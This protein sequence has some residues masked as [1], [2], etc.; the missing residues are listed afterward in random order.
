MRKQEHVERV[1]IAPLKPRY[2]EDLLESGHTAVWGS[3]FDEETK[4]WGY[5][6]CKITERYK[7]CPLLY[8]SG[9]GGGDAIGDK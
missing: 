3:Y 8:R 1:P 7:P 6:C 5:A 9:D 4:K 2:E